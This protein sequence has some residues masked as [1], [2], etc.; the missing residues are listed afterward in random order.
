MTSYDY[1]P[2]TGA[3]GNN[4]LLRGMTV[5]ADGQARRTCYGYDP[6]GNRIWETKPR[7]GLAACY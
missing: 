1:G 5:T 3:V 2:D 7:A 6:Q 4:L